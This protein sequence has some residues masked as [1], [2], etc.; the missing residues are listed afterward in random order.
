MAYVQ[1]HW[2]PEAVA[3]L[4]GGRSIAPPRDSTSEADGLLALCEWR[5]HWQGILHWLMGGFNVSHAERRDQ[6]HWPQGPCAS[7]QGP[8][9][10]PG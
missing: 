9:A 3:P 2:T 4:T 5:H 10:L 7:P 6:L 1:W 8:C